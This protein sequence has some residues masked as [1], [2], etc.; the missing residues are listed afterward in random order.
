V[1][2]IASK[3]SLTLRTEVVDANGNPFCIVY[4]SN[5]YL[6]IV[7]YEQGESKMKFEDVE[8]MPHTEIPN[9]V[10]AILQFGDD[11]KLSIVKSDFSYGGTKGLY[12]IGVF[13][14]HTMVELPGITKEGDSVKGFLSPEEVNGIITKMKTI[15]GVEPVQ[16]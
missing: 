16:I 14:S 5:T 3:I 4:L 2:P 9:G 15:T 12:E 6:V 11:Y 10:Q 8:M 7:F 13:K 1:R